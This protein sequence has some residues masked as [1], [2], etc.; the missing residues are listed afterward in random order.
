MIDEVF[1]HLFWRH[2]GCELWSEE[3]KTCYAGQLH[4]RYPNHPEFA[5]D[6]LAPTLF[7]G[8]MA[9]AAR[10]ADLTG[11]DRPEKPWLNGLPRLIFVS[12]MGDALSDQRAVYAGGKPGSGG[13][14][15]P[16]DFLKSEM[17]DTAVSDTGRHHHWL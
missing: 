11:T 4:R 3:R 2:T 8:Q 5:P 10:Y 6:F 15:V 17:M 16:F 9:K 1:R 12:D 7:P 14:G 13:G